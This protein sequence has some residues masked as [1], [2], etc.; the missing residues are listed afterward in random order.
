M[1]KTAGKLKFNLVNIFRSSGVS[2]RNQ[3]NIIE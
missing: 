2:P 3:Y 1:K